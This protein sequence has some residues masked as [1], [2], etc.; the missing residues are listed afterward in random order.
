MLITTN[1]PLASS[2]FAPGVPDVLDD[3]HTNSNILATFVVSIYVLGFAFGPL[4]FAPMSEIVGRSP[5]YHICNFLFVL[6]TIL[7]AVSVNM[8]MLVAFRFLS[9]FAGV[10]VSLAYLSFV[11][12]IRQRSDGD[13]GYHDRQWQ[14]RRSSC[15]RTARSCNGDVV[16]RPALR[17]YRGT[18]NCI[19]E[20]FTWSLNTDPRCQGP[21]AGGFLVQGAGW[22][23]VF[24]LIA[25]AVCLDHSFSKVF[26]LTRFQA[27]II[28]I[29]CVFFLKET[30]ADII[31]AKKA[32]RLRKETGNPEWHVKSSSKP[33]STK[34]LII[35]RFVQPLRIL[36]CSSVASLMCIYVAVL[37]G[38][39]YILFTTFTFVSGVWLFAIACC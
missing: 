38:L 3:F 35:Q 31:L 18:Y 4:V 28:T 26:W 37:Y 33:V 1:R 22:R 34:H 12:S 7:S 16:S 14:H 9:G 8:G 5:V 17:S 39:L 23:W 15:S 32:I 2:M 29:F 21:I 19:R 30:H 11:R 13:S 20:T 10:G 36:L 24:W 25:L 6:F 27:G